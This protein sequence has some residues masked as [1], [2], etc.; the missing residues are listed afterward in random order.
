MNLEKKLRSSILFYERIVTN[1]IFGSL[2]IY[3][4]YLFITTENKDSMTA[5]W[6]IVFQIYS[7]YFSVWEHLFKLSN[8]ANQSAAMCDFWD[9]NPEIFD[10]PGISLNNF[11]QM[12]FK[13]IS[14]EYNNLSVLK[15]SNLKISSGETI[16]II[17]ESGSGK[18]TSTNLIFKLIK[19]TKGELLINDKPIDNYSLCS[20]RKKIG[21]V[22]QNIRLFEE[23]TVREN[24]I[25]GLDMN[26]KKLTEV[27]EL[28]YMDDIDLDKKGSELSLGQKQRIVLA[29]VLYTAA[30]TEIFIFD[31]YL[32]AVDPTISESIHLMILNMIKQENKVGLFISH[33]HSI[34]KQC[35]RVILLQDKQFIEITN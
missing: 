15:D 22:P 2:L 6:L 30:E 28:V 31:E 8:L 1:V 20:L 24:I 27:L 23:K 33:D 3:L 34:A 16:A 35:E 29:R 19:P 11:K 9:I 7:K 25:I 5:F 13:N 10:T 21:I 32:S 12:E 4:I 14:F 17:G 26:P 18:S